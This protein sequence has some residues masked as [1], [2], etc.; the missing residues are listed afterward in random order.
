MH[1]SRVGR[2]GATNIFNYGRKIFVASILPTRLTVPGSPRMSA[3][4]WVTVIFDKSLPDLGLWYALYITQFYKQHYDIPHWLYS[5]EKAR[6]TFYWSQLPIYFFL[7]LYIYNLIN[8]HFN[9]YYSLLYPS[10]SLQYI[11]FFYPKS[12]RLSSFLL[13]LLSL[14][15]HRCTRQVLKYFFYASADRKNKREWRTFPFKMTSLFNI[16]LASTYELSPSETT[17]SIG[18]PKVKLR[19]SRELGASEK[20]GREIM[21]KRGSAMSLHFFSPSHHSFR[22]RFPLN[23]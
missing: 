15:F 10:E 16:C 21:R 7:I 4:A 3:H 23:N 11:I 19:D 17:S 20:R 12:K 6:S 22:P 18:F 14:S 13:L 2:K 1:I 5:N 9:M 8:I